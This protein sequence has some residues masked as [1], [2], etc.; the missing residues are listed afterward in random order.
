M[1]SAIRKLLGL[2]PRKS[3][4]ADHSWD[5]SLFIYV[6]I[7]GDIQ[8]LVRGERFEDPL[9]TA[10]A[11]LGLGSISGGGSQLDD[12]YP[13]GR[14]RVEFCGIDVDVKDREKARAF[15]MKKLVELDAPP[16]T[17]LHYTRDGAKLLDRYEN[18]SWSEGLVRTVMHPGF[19]V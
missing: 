11:E 18:G 7:P 6:K 2:K 15:L 12:P 8:P 5:P 4:Q 17:E 16:G 14:P 1:L 13:D 9:Q 3:T 19:G 10:L